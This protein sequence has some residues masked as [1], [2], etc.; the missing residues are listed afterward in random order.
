M[1]LGVF[2]SVFA[3]GNHGELVIAQQQARPKSDPH[4]NEELAKL[5]EDDQRDRNPQGGRAIDPAVLVPRDKNR[6]VRIKAL[7]EAGEI[8]TGKDYYRAAMILQHASR[9]EDC[10]L[11]HD[12]CT[13]AL[14]KGE[15][16]ARWLAAATEDR[17]LMKIGR[18]QRFGTQYHSSRLDEPV[19]LYEVGPGVTDSLRKELGVPTLDEARTR[20]A[21]MDKLFKVKK[22]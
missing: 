13:V 19:R 1:A 10:L 22:P 3:A 18:P 9:P 21:E 15:P 7:Y 8:R 17:F 20:A 5:Y 6:E 2:I 4:D 12:F 11:A 14:A 16:D